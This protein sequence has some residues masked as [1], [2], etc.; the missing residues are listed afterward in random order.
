[1]LWGVS[2]HHGVPPFSVAVSIMFVVLVS[3]KSLVDCSDLDMPNP[4]TG[5]GVGMWVYTGFGLV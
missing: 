5:I 1:M 3:D 2:V 4:H